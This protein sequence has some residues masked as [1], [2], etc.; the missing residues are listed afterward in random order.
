MSRG[1]LINNNE[2]LNNLLDSINNTDIFDYVKQWVVDNNIHYETNEYEKVWAALAVTCVRNFIFEND[3]SDVDSNFGGRG[4]NVNN[5]G[6]GILDIH[7]LHLLIQNIMNIS[8]SE[9]NVKK[10]QLYK[11]KLQNANDELIEIIDWKISNF[12]EDSKTTKNI[13]DIFNDFTNFQ[14][15]N[16]LGCCSFEVYK[17]LTSDE[18]KGKSKKEIQLLHKGLERQSLKK[19][20]NS[21]LKNPE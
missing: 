14:K 11:I 12:E 7:I 8:Y 10:L 13:E 21:E 6:T 2:N 5:L 3:L 4:L 17:I 15:V 19:L 18:H 20:L 16:E 1:R 9:S